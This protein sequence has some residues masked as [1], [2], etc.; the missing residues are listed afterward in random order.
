[1]LPGL[2]AQK[3]CKAHGNKFQGRHN[4][5][6]YHVLHIKYQILFN[7]QKVVQNDSLK[8]LSQHIFQ[9]AHRLV[10]VVSRPQKQLARVISD[11]RTRKIGR[12]QW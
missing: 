10:V 1:M 12:A 9:S 7:S 11:I 4:R 6:M 5:T 3:S 2:V 8:L